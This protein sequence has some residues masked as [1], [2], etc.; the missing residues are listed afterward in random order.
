MI[1]I[2]VDLPSFWDQWVST[3]ITRY[4]HLSV[5]RILFFSKIKNK[6][7]KVNVVFLNY[8]YISVYIPTDIMPGGPYVYVNNWLFTS[9]AQGG[10]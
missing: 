8:L 10:N 7:K 1:Y 4:N 6:K 5:T 3:V 9:M 2:C